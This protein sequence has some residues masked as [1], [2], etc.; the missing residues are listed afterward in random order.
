MNFDVLI[1]EFVKS[2][3]ISVSL[4]KDGICHF[5]INNTIAVSLEKTLDEKGFFLY[6]ILSK[7]PPGRELPFTLAALEGNLFG[8]ET[9]LSSIGYD[10][11][12]NSLVLFRHFDG[13]HTH[14][15]DLSQGFE[16]FLQIFAHWM[17][18]LK[19]LS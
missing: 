18:K 13:F 1:N 10:P 4:D 17:N 15:S 14:L 11:Q 12:T 7:I 5:L 8:K 9:N 6:T 19:Q 2:H 16:E 3:G